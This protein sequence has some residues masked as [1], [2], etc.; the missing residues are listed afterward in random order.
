MIKI[1]YNVGNVQ[2]SPL[3]RLLII[4]T[5]LVDGSIMPAVFGEFYGGVCMFELG[6]IIWVKWVFSGVFLWVWSKTPPVFWQNLW[7]L[8]LQK[9]LLEVSCFAMFTGSFCVFRLAVWLF[10]S[11]WSDTKNFL[12]CFDSYGA[13]AAEFVG[14]GARGFFVGFRRGKHF[15]VQSGR[16]NLFLPAEHRFST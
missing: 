9:V 5:L 15:L 3:F 1:Y 6:M 7:C 14:S 4:E 12:S 13:I 8:F 16:A 10:V 11:V 2:V